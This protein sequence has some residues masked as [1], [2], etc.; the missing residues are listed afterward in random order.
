MKL[1][2][3]WT[4]QFSQAPWDEADYPYWMTKKPWYNGV[5]ELAGGGAWKMYTG[6]PKISDW[7]W[8]Q[9]RVSQNA[10]L[11]LINFVQ[12]ALLLLF[13]HTGPFWPYRDETASKKRNTPHLRQL[14]EECHTNSHFW[15]VSPIGIFGTFHPKQPIFLP[16]LDTIIGLFELYR[17]QSGKWHN[18]HNRRPH[19]PC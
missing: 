1:R 10:R 6:L 13:T 5:S 7:G 14:M 17:H 19:I 2:A 15:H 3:E 11:Q 12:A 16:C 4:A 18:R 9:N 8:D